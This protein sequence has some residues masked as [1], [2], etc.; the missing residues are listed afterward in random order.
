MAIYLTRNPLMSQVDN[1]QT[2]QAPQF[3]WYEKEYTTGTTQ[4]WIYTPDAEA[5]GVQMVPTSAGT[6]TVELTCS[7]K[8]VIENGTPQVTKWSPGDVT[9]TTIASVA[10]VTAFRVNM[11]SGNWK[12]SVRA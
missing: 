12:I 6:A 5:V 7:P 8:Y 1:V 10:A 11:A 3:E 9:A 4:E 2:P